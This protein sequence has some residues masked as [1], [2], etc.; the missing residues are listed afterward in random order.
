MSKKD[1]KD[2]KKSK[3][4]GPITEQLLEEGYDVELLEDEVRVLKDMLNAFI[5]WGILG[6]VVFLGYLIAVNPVI[7]SIFVNILRILISL[8]GA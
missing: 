7:G 8:I 6:V 3:K 2:E 5:G 4:G 1:D